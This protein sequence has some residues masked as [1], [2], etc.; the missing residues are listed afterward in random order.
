MQEL[1]GHPVTFQEHFRMPRTTFPALRA[2]VIG[3]GLLQSKRNTRMSLDQMLG[4]FLWMVGRNVHVRDAQSRFQH[5]KSTIHHVFHSIQDALLYLHAD[6]VHPPP[7]HIPARIQKDWGKMNY[8]ADVRGAID[9]THIAAHIPVKFRTPFRIRKGTLPQDV[10]AGCTL[11][12][13]FFY[14]LPGWGSR[15]SLAGASFW[16]HNCGAMNKSEDL[17][18]GME[19]GDGEWG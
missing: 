17:R 9:G 5:S 19:R 8:F 2:W 13:Y 11:D 14:I 4:I 16:W 18:G 15:I 6:Y 7:N 3:R 12:M 10:L 1:R